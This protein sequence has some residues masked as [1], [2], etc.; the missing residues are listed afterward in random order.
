[1]RSDRSRCLS[2]LPDFHKIPWKHFV[3][4]ESQEWLHQECKYSGHRNLWCATGAIQVRTP[5][6]CYGKATVVG[7]GWGGCTITMALGHSKTIQRWVQIWS[8]S[9]LRHQQRGWRKLWGEG[10]APRRAVQNP[11]PQ[12]SGVSPLPPEV[13]TTGQPQEEPRKDPDGFLSCF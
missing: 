4:L 2:I 8:K 10:S 12:P 7:Q 6:S 9:G 11:E 3:C 5:D 13:L 1:M